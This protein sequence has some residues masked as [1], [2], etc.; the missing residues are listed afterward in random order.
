MVYRWRLTNA[1]KS[2]W[3]KSATISED[4]RGVFWLSVTT[5]YHH[6]SDLYRTLLAA[7][8][9]FGRHFFKGGKWE[10]DKR[11]PCKPLKRGGKG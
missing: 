10:P 4:E 6:N 2:D 3:V 11:W 1:D 9:S 8:Q 7:K 5:I